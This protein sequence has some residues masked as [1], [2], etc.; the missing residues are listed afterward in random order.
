MEKETEKAREGNDLEKK[1][2]SKKKKSAKKKSEQS[3]DDDGI[4]TKSPSAI[5][6]DTIAKEGGEK[7]VEESSKEKSKKALDETETTPGAVAVPKAVEARTVDDAELE[8]Q[9]REK[10]VL[11]TQEKYKDI[12][13]AEAV[14]AK[15]NE[16]ITCTFKKKHLWLVGAGAVVC[17]ALLLGLVLGLRDNREKSEASHSP[18]NHEDHPANAPIPEF[19]EVVVPTEAPNTPE[20]LCASAQCHFTFEELQEALELDGPVVALCGDVT[21]NSDPI[22]VRRDGVTLVGCCEA[23]KC[24]IEGSG[25]TRN[26]VVRGA[27]F[28]LQNIALVG[29]RCN[30]P[31]EG[32]GANLQYSGA[33]PL[34]V[35]DSELRNGRCGSEGGNLYASVTNGNVYLKG[36]R[37]DGGD[38]WIVGGALVNNARDTHVID[39]E[40]L[41]SRGSGFGRYTGSGRSLNVNGS[42]FLNNVAEYGGMFVSYFGDM[43]SIAVWNTVFE[44]NKGSEWGG[45]FSYTGGPLSQFEWRGNRGQGNDGRQCEDAFLV[46]EGGYCYRVD[47]EILP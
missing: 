26:L 42:L 38:G 28:T 31:I 24:M 39:C 6:S 18:P 13:M 20:E 41:N 17:L 23:R 27:D 1:P 36:S 19:V 34:S 30:N 4:Q 44:D 9:M 10:I 33:G 8:A 7:K 43:P 22:I 16:D 32:G 37:F 25:N 35:I 12:P 11:E 40:F 15:N 14:A 29:G 2:Y 45:A 3:L 47:A 5:S 21:I 46:N